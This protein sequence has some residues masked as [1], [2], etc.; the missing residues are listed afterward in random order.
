M[1]TLARRSLVMVAV[2]LL[3]GAGANGLLTTGF[4]GAGHS[5]VQASALTEEEEAGILY[6]R[7]EEK[8]ARDV[9]LVLA[10]RWGLSMFTTIAQ[11]EVQHME[12]M[13]GLIERYGL[14]DPAAGNDV[15][16]F[17]DP[18]L[19]ELYDDLTAQGL[20]SL[21]GALTAGGY[22]EE[23]DVVD[24]E[25]RIAQT[26][27]ADIQ[28]VYDNLL[29]GSR[30]HLRSFV[31]EFE[32]VIGGTYEIQVLEQDVFDAIIASPIETGA[33]DGK[34]GNGTAGNGRAQG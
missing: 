5:A 22:I 19:Q 23:F 13:L 33:P 4:I 26:D 25:E 1:N 28:Q 21:D 34:G 11:S 27:Q 10:D 15:G 6:I 12:A 8:L 17:V 14:E 18:S 20:A 7:E 31:Q 30:N 9:Y 29:R 3:L 16:E 2:L 32:R 24:L